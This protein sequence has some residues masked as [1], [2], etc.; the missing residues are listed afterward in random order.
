MPAADDVARDSRTVFVRGVDYATDEQ[1][2]EAAFGEIGPLR[3]CFLIRQKGQQQHKGYGFVH[4]ALLEDAQ[5]AV[6]ELSNTRLGGRTIQVRR[7]L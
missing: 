2:L 7:P 3:S 5:R 6:D 4:F 1:A